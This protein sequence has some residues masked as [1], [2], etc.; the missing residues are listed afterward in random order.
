MDG[1]YGSS[2]HSDLK[3]VLSAIRRAIPELHGVMIASQDGLAIAHD[4]PEADAERIAAMAATALGLGKRISERTN[5][6]DLSET[7]IHG[8]T[9]CLVVYGAGEDAVLVM[10]GPIESNLGL[11]RIEARVAAVE[12]KQL[13]TRA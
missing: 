7:V 4:F 9:G 8:R 11:M 10:Q 2:K 13:L 6:G 12:I 5:M 1:K 3:L